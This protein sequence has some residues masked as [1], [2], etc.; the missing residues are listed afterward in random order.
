[1]QHLK[2]L[3]RNKDFSR[4]WTAQIVSNLGDSLTIWG[5]LF[6]V[7]RLT[8]SEASVAGVLIA[9]ALPMLLV[10]M[11]AGVWVDRLNRKTV[12]VVSDV[13]R[14]SL[15][16]LLL[17][18]RTE[19]WLWVMYVVVFL[20]SAVGAFFN[21]AKTALLPSIVGQEQ[22][23][24]ANSV[25]ETSRV[26]FGLLGT[27]LAGLIIG[28]TDSFEPIFIID[29]LTFI[30]SA[31]QVAR[32]RV[33]SSP[34]QRSGDNPPSMLG[35]LR[36]GIAVFGRSRLLG[37]LIVGVALAM[38]GLGAVNALLVPFVVGILGLSETWF[39]LLEASQVASMV[40]SGAIVA[41]LASRLRPQLVI[42]VCL[43]AVGVLIAFVAPLNAIWQLMLILFLLGW[44][45]TPLQASAATLLQTETPPDMLGR[46]GAAFNAVATG[47]SVASMA[48]AGTLAVAI[49]TRN[50]F[51]VCGVMVGLAAVVSG[52][53]LL[54]GSTVETAADSSS[55]QERMV[56]L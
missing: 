1:M 15:V 51:V 30:V 41:A 52:F 21:P 32:I 44:F 17:F 13:L 39:G 38:F 23:M 33:D 36:E 28:L 45:I 19:Q 14:A 18:A 48:A 24:A 6:L 56:A 50:V 49:G 12:M 53:M 16:L 2:Q 25:S 3:L 9:G 47:A 37:G 10:S 43:G 8:G 11:P 5:L 34:P 26:I 46:A 40:L 31:V 22:L 42:P 55:D 4:L 27:T 35:E 54:G 20:H 7:M 29:A